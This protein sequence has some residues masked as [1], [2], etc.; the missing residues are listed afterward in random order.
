M[1]FLLRAGSNDDELL[2]DKK[3]GG[4]IVVCFDFFGRGGVFFRD[5]AQG[6]ERAN[7]VY[8]AGAVW[9]DEHIAFFHFFD[10]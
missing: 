9:Y 1:L 5:F 4:E 3:R 6:F 7:R 2:T 8:G 10:V